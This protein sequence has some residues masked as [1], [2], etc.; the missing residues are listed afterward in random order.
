MTAFQQDPDANEARR[1]YRF[2]ALYSSPAV[3]KSIPTVFAPSMK[4][5]TA[6]VPKYRLI[7]GNIPEIF[8]ALH[9]QG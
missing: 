6:I 5:C 1:K 9:L 7:L 8:L 3:C 2:L 4:Y